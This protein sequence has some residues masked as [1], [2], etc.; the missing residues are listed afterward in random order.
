MGQKQRQG[1]YAAGVPIGNWMQ[2]TPDGKVV[3]TEDYRTRGNVQQAPAHPEQLE[4]V[5]APQSEENSDLTI[6]AARRGRN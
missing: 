3:Q 1:D 5:S 6:G 2:W 4:N